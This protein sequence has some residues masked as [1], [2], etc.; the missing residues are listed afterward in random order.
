MWRGLGEERLYWGR[1]EPDL[2]SL[3]RQGWANCVPKDL[4]RSFPSLPGGHV[5][6]YP[7]HLPRTHLNCGIGCSFTPVGI[8]TSDGLVISCCTISYCSP[9]KLNVPEQSGLASDGSWLHWEWGVGGWEYLFVEFGG[10]ENGFMWSSFWDPIPEALSRAAS[11]VSS[12]DPEQLQVP[13][14]GSTF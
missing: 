4:N 8:T 3:I 5:K 10:H 6:V 2:C 9:G 13:Y 14:E 7:T 11:L 12:R 1:L